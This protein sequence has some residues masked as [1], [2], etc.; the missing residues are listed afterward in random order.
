ML[1]LKYQCYNLLVL[2]KPIVMYSIK[3]EDNIKVNLTEIVY[4]YVNRLR[5]RYS[6]TV[7][8]L[9]MFNNTIC[10]ADS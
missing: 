4:E 9:G 2:S 6:S 8:Y 3:L 1:C 7:C 10:V 5:I